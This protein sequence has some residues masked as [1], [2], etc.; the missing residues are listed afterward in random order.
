MLIADRRELGEK[1]VACFR[2]QTYANKSLLIFDTGKEAFR[3][4]FQTGLPEQWWWEESHGRTIGE[5]RNAAADIASAR[6][7]DIIVHWDSD[8]WSHPRRIEEQVALLREE[9]FPCVGYR[10]MLFWQEPMEWERRD[11]EYINRQILNGQAWAWRGAQNR[12]IGTSLAYWREVWKAFP[13]ARL[14]I[15]DSTG[16][17]VDF[18]R[19]VNSCGVPS[20]FRWAG[21]TG[22]SYDDLHPRMIAR[23]H[24]GNTSTGYREVPSSSSWTRVAE[25]DQLCMRVMA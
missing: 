20:L 14:P 21:P 7:A 6:D 11:G 16:E 24:A 10:D 8:D 15:G 1:A 22:S 17:D 3:Q 19:R 13:F 4:D 2:R 5:L 18:V 9:V 25:F 23:I 12:P